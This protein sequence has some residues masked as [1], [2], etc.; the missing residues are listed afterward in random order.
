MQD[1]L[2]HAFITEICIMEKTCTQQPGSCFTNALRALQNNIAKIYNARTH[3]YGDNFMLELCMCAQSMALGTHTKFQLENLTRSMISAIHK[4]Q[5]NNLESSW[6]VFETTP[7]HPSHNG[8]MSSWLKS[9][10]N[11]FALIVI[12][13][14]HSHHNFAHVTTSQLSWHVR[15]YDLIGWLFFM[16]DYHEYLWDFDYEFINSLWNGSQEGF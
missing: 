12:L 10:E 4:F 3:I 5:E 6:N 11:N 7:R 13:T 15:H 2:R 14:I 8:F 16:Q 9:H 1:Y